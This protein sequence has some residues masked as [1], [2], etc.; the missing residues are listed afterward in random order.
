[1]LPTRKFYGIQPP[2]NSEHTTKQPSAKDISNNSLSSVLEW[3]CKTCAIRAPGSDPAK[4][5]KELVSANENRNVG[6][7]G[8]ESGT[9][10]GIEG[11]SSTVDRS[12]PDDSTPFGVP[13][14]V[15]VKTHTDATNWDWV[16]KVLKIK[17]GESASS[18]E[19]RMQTG[20][21]L[22]IKVELTFYLMSFSVRVDLK[23]SLIMAALCPA[24]VVQWLDHLDTMCSRA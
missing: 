8:K 17:S 10:S 18:P 12:S 21:F 6:C 1:L 3:T 4:L 5:R 19:V 24:R 2:P 9:K 11:A 20:K 16:E 14:K 15:R 22:F 7:T 13:P 23:V